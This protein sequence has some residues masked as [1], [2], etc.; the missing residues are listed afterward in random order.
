MRIIT[1]KGFKLNSLREQLLDLYKDVKV[2]IAPTYNCAD[3]WINKL[4]LDKNCYVIRLNRD[5]SGIKLSA[6]TT[7]VLFGEK[8]NYPEEAYLNQSMHKAMYFELIEDVER[9]IR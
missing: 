8:F 1:Q 9:L 2:V 6:D 3:Y 7:L 5:L 4:N